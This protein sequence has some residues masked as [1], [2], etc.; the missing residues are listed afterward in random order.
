M[1]FEPDI[2]R[3]AKACRQTGRRGEGFGAGGA[4][5]GA[6]RQTLFFTAT[7]PAA[8][9]RAAAAFTSKSAVQIRIGQGSDGKQ[10]TANSSVTQTVLVI[11]EEEKL[12]RLKQ[13]LEKELRPGETAIVFATRKTTCD[14][15]EEMLKSATVSSNSGV[16]DPAHPWVKTMGPVPLCAW[17]RAIHGDR[18]Q[19]EREQ[20]LN[21]FRSMTTKPQA[22]RKAVLVATDVA[23]R[24]LDIPG[25]ALVVV[26]DF[27]GEADRPGVDSY[28][29]RIGRTGRAGRTGKSFTFFT[30]EDAGAGAFVQLLRNAQ[31]EV[32]AELDALVKQ[33]ASWGDPK[34]WKRSGGGGK[35][36]LKKGYVPSSGRRHR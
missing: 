36:K 24:G 6:R 30:P 7:W 11:P 3:I 17:V 4:Q 23:S 26:F 32:P 2:R 34:W 33:E 22:H 13:I 31:Q 35:G 8:V 27:G 29:H 9:Q 5:A 25:V 16:R 10:V 21:A 12:S 15:L 18:E 1:G 28:V 19:W 20:N 14:Q